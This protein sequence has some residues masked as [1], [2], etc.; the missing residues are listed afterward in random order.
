MLDFCYCPYGNDLA[1]QSNPE[2]SLQVRRTLVGLDLLHQLGVLYLA[3]VQRTCHAVKLRRRVNRIVPFLRIEV[4]LQVGPVEHAPMPRK[5]LVAR[6]EE[7]VR[8]HAAEFAI[9]IVVRRAVVKHVVIV[10]FCW[11]GLGLRCGSRS[12]LGLRCGSGVG[13]RRRVLVCLRCSR[14]GARRSGST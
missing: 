10:V 14:S 5:D 9:G 6:N 12:R 3:I 13:R 2:S 7:V 11:L 8:A 4:I 1:E